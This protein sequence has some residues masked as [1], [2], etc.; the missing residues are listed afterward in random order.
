[1]K[2]EEALA[3][4]KAGGK[5]RRPCLFPGDF[6]TLESGYLFLYP[7]DNRCE[8]KKAPF[9]LVGRDLLADDWEVVE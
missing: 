4:L 6:V 9:A 2:F 7:S 8:L 5:I 1:M 3:V